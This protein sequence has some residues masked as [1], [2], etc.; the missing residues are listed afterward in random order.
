MSELLET[1]YELLETR[2]VSPLFTH[3]CDRRPRLFTPC[4]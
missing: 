1:R 2:Y 3:V 4:L